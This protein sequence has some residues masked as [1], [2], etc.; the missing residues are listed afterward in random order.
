VQR[1]LA[2]TLKRI[3]DKGAAGFY[4]GETARLIVEEMKRGNGLISYADL[5]NY[6]AKNRKPLQFEYKGYTI[7]SMPPP[8]SGGVLLL[9]MLKMVEKRQ[10]TAYGFQTAKSVQLMTEAERRAYADRAEHLGDPDFY[11][12]PLQTMTSEAYIAKRMN[13]YDSTTAGKSSDVKA[14]NIESEETTH[15][16]IMDQWGNMVSVTTTLNGGYGSKTVVGGGGFLLNNEMDDFSVKPG[17]P[18]MYGAVG[19]EANAIL[20]GKRMLSSMTPSV[21]LRGSKPFMVVGTPGGTTIPTSV[22]QTIINV[23]DFGMNASDAINKSKFHHQWLPD[24]IQVEKDFPQDVRKQLEDLGYKITERPS[25]GRM[26]VIKITN[27]KM[28]TAADKRGDDSVAG[29]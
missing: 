15:L 3:R 22:Y 24:E 1:D 28:E 8:S 10:L 23:I 18:N 26:E 17:V 2:N 21:V 20:P 29:F 4:E 7:V 12:V 9:Q 13:D 14:G 5:K 16:S 11:K 19:G 27:G 6:K 25:I